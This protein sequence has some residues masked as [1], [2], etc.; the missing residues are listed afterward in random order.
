MFDSLGLN[1]ADAIVV[2]GSQLVSS[3]SASQASICARRFLVFCLPQNGQP[4]D[5]SDHCGRFSHHLIGRPLFSD[6]I[7]KWRT[8]LIFTASA[9][10]VSDR[11]AIRFDHCLTYEAFQAR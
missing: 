7:E 11:I 6:L 1:P 8:G 3:P 10:P 2:L 4:N 5:G 9:V